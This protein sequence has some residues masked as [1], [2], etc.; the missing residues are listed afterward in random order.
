M[1]SRFKVVLLPPPASPA[2]GCVRPCWWANMK[3]GLMDMSVSWWSSK[4]GKSGEKTSRSQPLLV[5]KETSAS[6]RLTITVGWCSHAAAGGLELGA[7][8]VVEVEVLHEDK[9]ATEVEASR[10]GTPALSPVTVEGP[11]LPSEMG[12]K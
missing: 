7:E 1:V 4:A 6:S 9:E 12:R 11:A 5:G 10:V 2:A 8:G 3:V